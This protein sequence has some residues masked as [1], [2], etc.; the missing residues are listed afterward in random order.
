M[1]ETTT[2]FIS[3]VSRNERKMLYFHQFH[4]NINDNST[5]MHRLKILTR[6]RNI[7]HRVL[8]PINLFVI[9]KI[10]QKCIKYLLLDVKFGI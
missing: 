5:D 3:T 4:Q 10:D 9:T 8:K 1:I 7:I 2:Q 6:K